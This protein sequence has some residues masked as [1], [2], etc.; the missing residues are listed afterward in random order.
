MVQS[1]EDRR[2]L[3]LLGVMPPMLSP[4]LLDTDVA[5]LVDYDS[6]T[7]LFTANGIPNLFQSD[8]INLALPITSPATFDLQLHVDAAGQF[9]GGVAGDDLVITGEIDLDIDGIADISGVLLTGEVTA[10]GFSDD[11]PTTDRFDFRISITGGA[12]ATADASSPNYFAGKDIGL[13]ITNQNSTFAGDFSVDFGGNNKALLTAIDPVVVIPPTAKIGSSVWFDSNRNGI[14]DDGATGINGVDVNL[15]RDVDGDGVAEPGG[16]DGPAIAS[17]QTGVIDGVSGQ[18]QFDQLAAGDY[19]VEFD[20]G[21]FPIGLEF[22]QPNAG[23]D[24]SLDSD[25]DPISG[26]TT[27][28]SLAAGQTDLSWDAGWAEIMNPQIAVTKY[29]GSSESNA[30]PGVEFNLGDPIVFTYLVTNPGNIPM[31]P[32][33]LI[34][35]NA[36]SNQ[37]SDDLVPSPV[38][39]TNGFHSG[40]TNTDGRLDPGEQWTYTAQIIASEIGQFT[41]VVVVTGTPVDQS[42]D[43]ID[44]D[45]TNDDA[46]FYSVVGVPGISLQTLTNGQDADTPAEAVEIAVADTVTWTYVVEN[47]GTTSFIFSDVMV[48][49]DAGTPSNNGD[50]FTPTLTAGSDVGG[51]L[52][53]S[54]GEVWEYTASGIAND[55]TGQSNG[56]HNVGSVTAGSVFASDSSHY[57]NPVNPPAADVTFEAEDYQWID[58]PWTIQSSPNA[59]GGS[60]VEAPDGTGSHYFWAPSGKSIGYNFQVDSAGNYELSALIQAKS[61]SANSIWLRVDNGRWIQWHTPTTGSEFQWHTVTSGWFRSETAF[62]LDAGAHTLE[63]RVREDGTRLDKFM[64]SKLATTTIVIDALDTSSVSGDWMIEVD[65]DGNEFWISPNGSGSHYF[66][67]PADDELTYEFTLEE[68]GNFELHALVSAASNRDNSLWVQIDNGDWIQ[69]HLSVTGSSFE[70]QTVTD[71][72]LRSQVSFDLS[73]GSHTLKFKVREDGVK[74]DKIAITDDLLIDLSEL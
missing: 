22:T 24:D 59:S 47:T 48:V 33:S 9:A 14:Q 31:S 4:P 60:F 41:N 25:A 73:A 1:L 57:T 64:V 12:L 30:A 18:Y 71:G 61:Q 28:I 55:V 50:D 62:N 17:T 54:P 43:A 49:D 69:W 36:T 53:L 34:D 15:Y 42:G 74:L 19:F 65:N 46:A 29:V 7:N 40:D 66:T 21:P 39:D 26:L 68:S 27:I 56:Y 23:I 32:V 8:P 44:D 3:A 10:F 58:Q 35:D 2:V 45:A 20:P 63:I 70:W 52:I 5:G 6:T 72:L 11:G 67:P 13:L 37:L 51:D 16:D 38:L